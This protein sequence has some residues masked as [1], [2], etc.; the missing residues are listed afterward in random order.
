MRGGRV[1]VRLHDLEASRELAERLATL[2]TEQTAAIRGRQD[3]AIREIRETREAQYKE[4]LD[5][6]REERTAMRAAHV[7]GQ[8]A[9]FVLET[10]RAGTEERD[11]SDAGKVIAN[12][13]RKHPVPD[14]PREQDR[15]P[16]TMAD[17]AR[18]PEGIEVR[19]TPPE[20]ARDL[21]ARDVAEEQA[22]E[23]ESGTFSIPTPE[24]PEPVKQ[25]PDLAAGAIGKAADYLSDQIGRAHV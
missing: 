25:M 10:R 9:E 4:L 12:D 15:G 3:E 16:V 2:K 5:R 19:Q 21:V 11:A 23:V 18:G 6:Q 20:I 13:N 1:G 17:P 14:V 7:Q 22:R 8:S 24:A